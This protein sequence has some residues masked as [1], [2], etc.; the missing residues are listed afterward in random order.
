LLV[1]ASWLLPVANAGEMADDLRIYRGAIDSM[2]NG[3]GLYDFAMPVATGASPF[4]YPPFAALIML[5]TQAIPLGSV[6]TGWILMQMAMT[7]VLVLLMVRGAGWTGQRAVPAVAWALFLL[8]APV[9]FDINLGQISLPIVL[10][11]L[12]D[13]ILLPPRWRG[14]L[15]GIAGAIKLTPMFFVP[16]FLITRQWRAA[17][18]ASAAFGVSTLIG[19]AVLPHESFRYWTSVVFNS[20]RIPN[21][22]SPRNLTI[23]GDLKMWQVPNGVQGPLWGFL[24]LSVAVLSLWAG[25][26]HYRAGEPVAAAI[27]IGI[28]T[29]AIGPIAWNHHL[30]WLVVA[31]VSMVLSGTRRTSVVG[32]VLLTISI[33]PSPIWPRE[34]DPVMWRQLV[35]MIPLI[36]T[37]WFSVAGLPRS[38]RSVELEPPEDQLGDHDSAT[39]TRQG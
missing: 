36:L 31:G 20:S 14:T 29:T 3:H 9:M 10:L 27:V 4:L 1:L 34:E 26:R 22:G 8:S 5:P 39:A 15:I 33:L 28:A 21:L 2:L 13:V 30:V 23:L 37:V 32:W 25:W 12:A 11:V 38:T 18:N 24:A 7:V 35:G 19:F 6:E 17:I 16:Y